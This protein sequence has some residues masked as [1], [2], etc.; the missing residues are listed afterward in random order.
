MIGSASGKTG[1]ITGKPETLLMIFE[2]DGRER[3]PRRGALV[4]IS[5]RFALTEETAPT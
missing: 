2:K 5:A 4:M 3:P 1:G